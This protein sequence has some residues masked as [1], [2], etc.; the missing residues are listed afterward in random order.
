MIFP[1]KLRPSQEYAV[2][3]SAESGSGLVSPFF[4]DRR[5]EIQQGVASQSSQNAA[6][7]SVLLQQKQSDLERPS[8]TPIHSSYNR[9]TPSNTVL[10]FTSMSQTKVR[11]ASISNLPPLPKPTPVSRTQSA[12]KSPEASA[13]NMPTPTHKPAKKRV[14]QRK[15]TNVV[16]HDKSV[17]ADALRPTS[18]VNQPIV[19]EQPAEPEEEPSPLAAKSAPRPASAMAGLQSKAIPTKKRP[20]TPILPPS[21]VKRRKMVD[22]ATQTQTLSGRDHTIARR[23]TP[24]ND[25]PSSVP[26][27]APAHVADT[28]SVASPPESYLDAVDKFVSAHKTRPAPKELWQAPGY[29]EADEERRQLL[30]NNFICNNLENADFLQLVQDTEKAWRRIGLGM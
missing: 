2:S 3:R 25:A 23:P 10:S 12:T 16:A 24:S 13:E 9:L 21:A 28:P 27:D 8:S 5:P 11:A 26:T 15:S 18:P 7:S 19:F 30:L 22:Q 14:A 6:S 1:F 4:S 29:A 17:P 20:A